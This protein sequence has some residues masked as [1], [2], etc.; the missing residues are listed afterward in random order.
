MW[1]PA[2]LGAAGLFCVSL[3]IAGVGGDSDSDR[4]PQRGRDPTPP[5]LSRVNLPGFFVG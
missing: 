3:G 4:P 2:C 5:A 1:G